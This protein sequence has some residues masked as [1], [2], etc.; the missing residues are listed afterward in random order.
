[1]F[2]LLLPVHILFRFLPIHAS[3]LPPL[4]V[5][6]YDEILSSRVSRKATL[7]GCHLCSDPLSLTTASVGKSS[8]NSLNRW[9]FPLLNLRVPIAFSQARLPE[10]HKLY[11]GTVTTAQTAFNLNLFNELRCVGEHQVL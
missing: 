8:S 1:M 7:N 10:D 4:L 9:N 5:F 6:Q 3:F 2:L 11:H